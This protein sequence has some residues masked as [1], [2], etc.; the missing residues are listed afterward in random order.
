[1]KSPMIIVDLIIAIL[2]VVCFT[3]N[4]FVGINTHDPYYL[5]L[6]LFDYLVIHLS[7]KNIENNI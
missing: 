6:G 1:M 3:Y 4:M 7:L 2:M 5:L